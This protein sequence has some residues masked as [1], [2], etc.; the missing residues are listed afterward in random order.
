MSG[1]L[2]LYLAPAE[3]LSRVFSKETL[4]YVGSGTGIVYPVGF[5]CPENQPSLQ[6]PGKLPLQRGL[7]LRQWD[8]ACSFWDQRARMEQE[9]D[10]HVFAVPVTDAW[11]GTEVFCTSA[12]LLL[13]SSKHSPLSCTPWYHPFDPYSPQTNRHICPYLWNHVILPR[14]Q[15]FQLWGNMS[16]HSPYDIIYHI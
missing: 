8:A 3:I 7:T 14:S 6:P 16:Y 11:R 13:C 2:L 12:S 9:V 10:E 4:L 1:F 15:C 5:C